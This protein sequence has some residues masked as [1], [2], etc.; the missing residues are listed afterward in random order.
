[1]D[2]PNLSQITG[3]LR[4]NLRQVTCAAAL[5]IAVVVLGYRMLG[6]LP[7]ALFA[8]GY[9]GGFFLWLARR[10][11]VSYKGIRVPYLLTFG[12]FVVHKYEER[13]ADFFP[14][15]SQ[16][17]GVPVPKTTDP[18]VFVLYVLAAAWLV[19]PWLVRCRQEFGYFLLWSFFLSMGVTELAH[20]LLPLLRE[21]PYGY[22]PGMWSVIALAPVAWW[23]LY[24]MWTTSRA[25]EW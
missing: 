22:F 5:T 6:W 2:N 13:T 15:L 12:L 23:G 11:R 4:E 21:E 14:A 9:A 24:R 16:L 25:E 1:M 7:A 8:L 18:M 10:A 3:F 19:A 20:Y 17:T